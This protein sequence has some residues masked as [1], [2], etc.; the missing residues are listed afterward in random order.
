[1]LEGCDFIEVGNNVWI[2]DYCILIAGKTGDMKGREVKILKNRD[3]K[4]EEGFIYI[5]SSIHFAQNC[6]IHGFGGVLISDYVG[7]ST[8]VKIYSMSNHYQ[9]FKNKS[10]IT[11]SNP[12]VKK[13]P[14]VFIKSP[15]VIK[16][17]V[18]VSINSIIL[19]G[20]IGENSFIAPMSLV[21]KRIPKNS[22]AKG[23]PATVA[24]ERFETIN[25][26]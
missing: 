22:I 6:L 14:I 16:E 12:M 25:E 24:K 2:D 13:L 11:Y 15:I 23:N 3:F 1:M 5:G 8:G 17:N 20:T 21:S 7:L 10:L 19:F 4:G 26:T 18:F 9:S